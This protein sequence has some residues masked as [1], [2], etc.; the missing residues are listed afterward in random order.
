MLK[1]EIQTDGAAYSDDDVLTFYGRHELRKN[2]ME[3][4]KKIDIGCNEGT[5]I[6]ICGNKVGKWKLD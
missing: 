2:L 5:I 1:I 6:D 4:A 3:I